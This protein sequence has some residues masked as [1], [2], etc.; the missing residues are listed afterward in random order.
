MALS[1]IVAVTTAVAGV[2]VA[3]WLLIKSARGQ[4]RLLGVLG[5]VLLL[6]GLLARFAF[7]W[8]IERLLGRGN[9]DSIVSILAADIVLGGLLTG[10]GLLLVTRAFVVAGWPAWTDKRKSKPK[11]TGSIR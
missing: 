9:T 10:V 6:L 1:Q 11:W 8:M 4:P 3:L 2:L 7:Q 5:S